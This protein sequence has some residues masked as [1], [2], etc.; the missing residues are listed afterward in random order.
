MLVASIPRAAINLH[1]A[2][3]IERRRSEWSTSLGTISTASPIH[4][5]HS[6]GL[7]MSIDSGVVGGILRY[8]NSPTGAEVLRW[9]ATLL[10]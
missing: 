1:A 4:H 2:P 6:L 10:V 8:S 5:H 9:G 7:H 3:T